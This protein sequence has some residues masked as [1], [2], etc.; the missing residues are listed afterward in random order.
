[1]QNV[2]FLMRQLKITGL[3]RNTKVLPVVLLN[4]VAWAGGRES[5]PDRE[6]VGRSCAFEHMYSL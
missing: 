1:M 5:T 3:V 2:G 4:V 6:L